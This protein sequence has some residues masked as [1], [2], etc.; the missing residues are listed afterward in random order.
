MVYNPDSLAPILPGSVGI[1]SRRNVMGA[2][3]PRTSKTTKT[4]SER[5]TIAS[6]TDMAF[7]PMAPMVKA[8]C[9]NVD[10]I[11]GR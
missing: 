7:S 5:I 10:S 9:S 3:R 11:L 8:T 2:I 6:T 4:L 1:L